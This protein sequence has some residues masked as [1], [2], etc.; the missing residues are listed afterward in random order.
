M[1]KTPEFTFINGKPFKPIEIPA[2]GQWQLF[3]MSASKAYVLV[4]PNGRQAWFSEAE[5]VA[6]RMKN[7]RFRF[8]SNPLRDLEKLA[9]LG[10]RPFHVDADF[11]VA[12]F[13]GRQVK[14]N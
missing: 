7:P 4:H 13:D 3:Q 6:I 12:A 1:A 5:V 10:L 9:K 2:T 8:T 11:D 14:P